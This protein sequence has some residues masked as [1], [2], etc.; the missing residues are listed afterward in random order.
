MPS[1][2][3]SPSSASTPAPRCPSDRRAAPYSSPPR[4]P[5]WSALSTRRPGQAG[6]VRLRPRR[7]G[8]G[9][10]HGAGDPPP[11]RS[12]RAEP[13]C[14]R[15]RG[16]D[17]PRAGAAVAEGSLRVIARLTGTPVART[18]DGLVLDVNGVGYLLRVSERGAARRRTAAR[19]R[20]HVS[21][22][23]GGRAPALRVRRAGRARSSSSS[24][25]PCRE[26]ARRSRCSI[27]SGS[28]PAE[29]RRSI[30]ARRHHPLP[31]HSRVGKKTAERIVLELKEK[32]GLEQVGAPSGRGADLVA[33]DALV[34]LGYSAVE[35]ERALRRHRS[36]GSARGA[37]APGAEGGDDR[38]VPRSGRSQ[39]EEDELDRSLRPRHLDDFVGQERVKEQLASRSR[40][41][42]RG[43]AARSRVARR[44]AG[45]REDE[46][47]VHRPRGDRRRHPLR[48]R[49]GAR[50]EGRHGVDPDRARARDVLFIDEIHRLSSAVEEVLYPALEDFRLDI[51][52]GQ[53]PRR[54]RSR[55]RCRRSRSSARRRAP[56]C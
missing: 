29:L 16:R 49:A 43:G 12:A 47:R 8:P 39:P 56:G 21:A 45:A 7:E 6:R 24:C 27:V 11:R 3:R 52:V 25:C 30:V 28:S 17:L 22:R 51:V 55:W 37:R 38:A 19:S 34:E 18:A 14:R 42:G 4:S 50:A 40:R 9:A 26:S 36:G 2:S 5:G 53:G 33:R 15:A 10:A 23:A 32:M 13:R 20:R 54:G 48:G 41:R 46:P 44:A 31:G 1:R 35:A